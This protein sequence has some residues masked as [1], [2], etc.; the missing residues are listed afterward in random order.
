MT[1]MEESESVRR[2][3]SCFG[4][5][6]SPIASISDC[7]EQVIGDVDL[8]AGGAKVEAS[9]QIGC[10]FNSKVRPPKLSDQI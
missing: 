5:K 3:I 8:P 9:E 1:C 6:W 4:R 7:G 2:M 10:R